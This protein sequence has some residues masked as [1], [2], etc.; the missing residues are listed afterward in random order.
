MK[1]SAKQQTEHY[2][3]EEHTSKYHSLPKFSPLCP[4]RSYHLLPLSPLT[5]HLLMKLFPLVERFS[6]G[7]GVQRSHLTHKERRAVEH[8]REPPPCVLFWVLGAELAHFLKVGVGEDLVGGEDA[9]RA[10]TWGDC[11]CLCLVGFLGCR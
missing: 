3:E 1:T 4:N 8:L 7:W 6:M 9:G 2:D 11:D 10:E 5:P